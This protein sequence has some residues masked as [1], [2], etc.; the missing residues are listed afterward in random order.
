MID[1]SIEI[2]DIFSNSSLGHWEEITKKM[3]KTENL[4]KKLLFKSI[5]GF[6]LYPLKTHTDFVCELSTFPLKVELAST[7]EK[8][9]IDL[10]KIHNAGASIIQEI[11]FGASEFIKAIHAKAK[12]INISI[13]LDSLYFANIAKLRALRFICERL[14]EEAENEV[15]FSFYAFNSLR[16][17]TLFDPWVNMLRNVTSSMAGIIGGADFINSFS[18]DELYSLMTK[19]KN[20]SLG[21]R[22]SLNHLKILLEESHLSQVKDYSKGSYTIEYLTK[23]IIEKSWALSH[24][25]DDIKIFSK[26]VKDISDKR[27]ELA[28][29]R[30]ITITG[31]NN[32]ANAEETLKNI[33]QI[34]FNVEEDKEDL[35]PVRAVS[36]EFDKLRSDFNIA[37]NPVS[38]VLFG[39]TAKLSARSNF[40]QNYFEVLGASVDQVLSLKDLKE[41]HH[42]VICATDED[43]EKQLTKFIA[44]VQAKKPK[45]IYLAG[46]FDHQSSDIIDCL[47]MGQDVFKTLL[48]FKEEV[49]S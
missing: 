11:A 18:Y 34:D 39:K 13:A 17:Q 49:C 38:I 24:S 12:H 29:S 47:H 28:R 44:D 3:L 21:L 8:I 15:S 32:F 14:N 9:D 16:E 35:F 48:H 25:I 42:V 6:E 2:K 40:C 41:N 46:K 31:V 19:N 10:S 1:Q 33:Y 43:Y 36:F 30:K 7:Q 5:E 45:S 20:T 37:K 22:Q 23:T 26:E 4:D 27:R